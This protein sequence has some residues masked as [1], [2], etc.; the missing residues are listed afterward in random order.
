MATSKLTIL[1][2]DDLRRRAKSVATLRGEH[3]TDVIIKALEECVAEALEEA[4]D[5][6]VALEVEE[7]LA[8]GESKLHDWK[9]VEAEVDSLQD[10]KFIEEQIDRLYSELAELKR[11]VLKHASLDRGKGSTAWNDLMDASAEISAKW[12]GPEA[13]EEIRSQREK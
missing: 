2:P 1:I 12:S 8:R 10:T 7:R 13:V 5:L 6:R 3:F 9:E 4:E 11:Y